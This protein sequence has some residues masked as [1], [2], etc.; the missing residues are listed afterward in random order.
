MQCFSFLPL[1]PSLPFPEGPK[2]NKPLKSIHKN[3]F[4]CHWIPCGSSWMDK[5]WKGGCGRK[6]STGE[7]LNTAQRA[8]N[9]SIG[10]A[11]HRLSVQGRGPTAP[12]QT[13]ATNH[14]Q[15]VS[16][17]VIQADLHCTR[18]HSS[19]LTPSFPCEEQLTQSWSRKSLSSLTLKNYLGTRRT[20]PSSPG[21]LW[22]RKES[23]TTSFQLFVKFASTRNNIWA[24]EHWL[25]PLSSLDC[26]LGRCPFWLFYKAYRKIHSETQR[27]QA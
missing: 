21:F 14:L 19:A 1:L 18:C 15:K 22:E 24:W 6:N 11:K 13:C 10:W 4:N 12:R 20:T 5:D 8:L 27:G 7:K 17:V 16:W 25:E 2:G 3:V 23:G 9:R 26:P